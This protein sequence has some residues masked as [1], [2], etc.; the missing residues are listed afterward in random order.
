VAPGGCWNQ[1]R[2]ARQSTIVVIMVRLLKDQGPPRHMKLPPPSTL[3]FQFPFMSKAPRYST[4]TLH[5]I[6]PLPQSP[7]C[8][9]SYRHDDHRNT[10]A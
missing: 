10:L 3:Y 6:P 7:A 5:H 1:R 9:M 8:F 2:L 4:G